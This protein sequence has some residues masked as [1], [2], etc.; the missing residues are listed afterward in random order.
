MSEGVGE[1][2]LSS[3]PPLPNTITIT[4]NRNPAV[5]LYRVGAMFGIVLLHTIV[6][7]G[8]LRSR[9]LDNVLLSCVATPFSLKNRS[10]GVE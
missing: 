3:T 9:G 7:G 4:M 8:Y 2:L 1:F 10:V 6:Q 5:E